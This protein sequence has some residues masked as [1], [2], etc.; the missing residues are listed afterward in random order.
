MF[1]YIETLYTSKSWVQ[2]FSVPP[3]LLHYCIKIY[4]NCWVKNA[5]L[6]QGVCLFY[7]LTTSFGRKS[8]GNRCWQDLQSALWYRCLNSLVVSVTRRKVWFM[9]QVSMYMGQC[10]SC[11]HITTLESKKICDTIQCQKNINHT[12]K[13]W[14]LMLYPYKIQMV[15][16]VIAVSKQQRWVLLGLLTVV[17]LYPTTLDCLWFSDE[18]HFHLG[19]MNKQNMRFWASKNPHRLMKTSLHSAK[20]TLWYA[21]SKQGLIGPS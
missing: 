1:K 10:C 9:V 19:F 18:V 3:I 4:T 8:T 12:I 17:Q 20:C 15:Q 14:N 21:V 7:G 2:T 13:W 16:I 11:T 5:K 6:P